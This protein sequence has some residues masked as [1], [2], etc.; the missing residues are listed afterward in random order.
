MNFDNGIISTFAGYVNVTGTGCYRLQMAKFPAVGTRTTIL[1]SV[2]ATRHLPAAAANAPPASTVTA[3]QCSSS[4]ARRSTI[5]SLNAA[6]VGPNTLAWAL[7]SVFWPFFK[8]GALRRARLGIPSSPLLWSSCCCGFGGRALRGKLPCQW[9][10]VIGSAGAF[11]D[12]AALPGGSVL[13]RCFSCPA[14]PSGSCRVRVFWVG[15]VA[16]T[17]SC[18]SSSALCL[19]PSGRPPVGS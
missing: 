11:W 3:S 2:T 15:V 13:T 17:A 10:V 14:C 1:Q 9:S 4:A 19:Q 7:S 18:S 16:A 5:Q 12:Q 8:W 6:K